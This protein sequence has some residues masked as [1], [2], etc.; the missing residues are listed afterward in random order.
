MQQES[1]ALAME[2]A[3]RS[4]PWMAGLAAVLIVTGFVPCCGLLVF[5]AGA[6]GIAYYLTPQLGVSPDPQ[7]K[8]AT[9]LTI[10]VGIG[11]AAMGSLIIATIAGQLLSF[12]V[13]SVFGLIEQ[14][15]SRLAVGLTFNAAF[16]VVYLIGAVIGGA[17]FGVLFAFLGALVGLDRA[18]AARYP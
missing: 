8:N 12:L 5:P 17:L 13:F 10:G 7:T 15:F 9:A 18:P 6:F 14:D 3:K 11:L 1:N 4:L 16:L 2:A